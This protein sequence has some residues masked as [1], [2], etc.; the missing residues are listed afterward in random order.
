MPSSN[1]RE[2]DARR[3][4]AVQSGDSLRIRCFSWDRE[5]IMTRPCPRV[6]QRRWPGSD[7]ATCSPLL[8]ACRHGSLRVL[9]QGQTPFDVAD[10]GVVEH[11]EKLQK[12]QSVVSARG[13]P[14][15]PPAP[16]TLLPPGLPAACQEETPR[17]GGCEWLLIVGSLQA[18]ES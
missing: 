10:E 16:A 12:K 9:C 13:W 4:S 3:L 18:A 11:L 5:R 15:A 8:F 17:K 14:S 2:D 7:R 1:K 6:G